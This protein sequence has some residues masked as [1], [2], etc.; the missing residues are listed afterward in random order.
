MAIPLFRAKARFPFLLGFGTL[1]AREATMAAP[2][3]ALHHLIDRLP[4]AEI[5]VALRLLKSLS[6]EEGEPPLAASIRRG[7][8]EADAGRTIICHSYDEMVEKVL[9]KE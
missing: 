2:R 1:M 8:T 5:G 7:I 3:E 6:Q 9:G 4:D